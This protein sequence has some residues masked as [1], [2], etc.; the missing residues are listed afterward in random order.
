MNDLKR[1]EIK[2]LIISLWDSYEDKAEMAK[3]IENGYIFGEYANNEHYKIDDLT[4]IIA[5]V[6]LEKNP[7]PV[8][9]EV[10]VEPI[11]E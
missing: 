7:L 10:I 6:Y 8:V 2:D 11:V 9:E 1:Q 5:E 4:A 3:H